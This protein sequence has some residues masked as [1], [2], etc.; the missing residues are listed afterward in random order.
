[1]VELCP[2]SFAQQRLWFLEQLEPGSCAYNLPTAIRIRGTLNV[3][4][5]SRAL[6]A[7]VRRHDSLRTTFASVDGQ[8]IASIQSDPDPVV[9]PVVDLEQV[10]EEDKEQ[11]A[12]CLAAEEGQRP[13][14]LTAGPLLRVLL[15]RLSATHHLLVLTIHHIVADGWSIDVMLKELAEFYT[16]CHSNCPPEVP[17]FSTGYSDFARW[18]REAV[19]D[20]VQT[21]QLEYWQQT[22]HGAPALLELP[23]DRLRPAV[24]S[25]KGHRYPVH[26]DEELVRALAELGAKE[27][28]T[29]FMMLL[30]AFETLLWRY[31]GVPDFV[32]GTPIAGRSHVEFEPLIGLFVN[33][34]PLR[35]NL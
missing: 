24:Q 10:A 6:T 13:F 20:D 9:L 18:Q 23:A 27:R 16:A 26:L 12:L 22:L 25:H 3:D 28:V 21:R 30:A 15:L 35:A 8:A 5:F 29:P 32:L 34:V 33:T 4:W 11:H 31:T 14:D 7:I 17:Q 1:M 2:V 19:A